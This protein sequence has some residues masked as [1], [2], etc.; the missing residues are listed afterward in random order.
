MMEVYDRILQRLEARGW[1]KPEVPVK[2]S[3]LEKLWIA[4]RHGML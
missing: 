4:V 2:V 1:N 3:K